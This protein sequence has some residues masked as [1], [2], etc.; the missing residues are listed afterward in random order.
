M[1]KLNLYISYLAI[2]LTFS[3]CLDK[4]GR[5]RVKDVTTAPSVYIVDEPIDLVAYFDSLEQ[6]CGAEVW[7]HCPEDGEEQVRQSIR[8]LDRYVSGKRKFYPA[9]DVKK[10]IKP[11]GF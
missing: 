7:V 4:G 3:S 2:I 6:N 11:N 1:G 9:E 10:G 8:E 5:R